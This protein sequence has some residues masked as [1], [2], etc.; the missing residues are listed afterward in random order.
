MLIVEHHMMEEETEMF[1][2][3]A[4]EV[5]EDLKDLQ[6]EMLDLKTHLLAS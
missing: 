3:A 4:A 6:D 5:V 1:P 2:L